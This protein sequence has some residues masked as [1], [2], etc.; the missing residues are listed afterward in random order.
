[1]DKVI[2]ALLVK[3]KAHPA[4]KEVWSEGDYGTK[5]FTNVWGDESLSK[6]EGPGNW[7]ASLKDGYTYDDCTQVHEPS[8]QKVLEALEGV[9]LGLTSKQQLEADDLRAQYYEDRELKGE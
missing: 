8:L 2:A 1:M 9:E 5:F 4:V 7:W 3:V 6:S